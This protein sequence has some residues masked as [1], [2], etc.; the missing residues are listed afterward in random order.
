[1]TLQNENICP[2]VFPEDKAC[3]LK[4][5]WLQTQVVIELSQTVQATNKTEKTKYTDWPACKVSQYFPCILAGFAKH[6]VFEVYE[7]LH[8]P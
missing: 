3:L 7:T 6:G 1:M 8:H 5:K 4:I 2:V